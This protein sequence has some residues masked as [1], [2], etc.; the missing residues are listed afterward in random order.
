MEKT[1]VHRRPVSTGSNFSSALEFLEGV[2][3]GVS[4]VRKMSRY[5]LVKSVR[6]SRFA[7]RDF[8]T[9]E[10]RPISGGFDACLSRGRFCACSRNFV[11]LVNQR[12]RRRRVQQRYRI[13]FFF[14]LFSSSKFRD[15]FYE[16]EHNSLRIVSFFSDARCAFLF[17]PSWKEEILE[18]TDSKSCNEIYSFKFIKSDE[19]AVKQGSSGQYCNQFYY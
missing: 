9:L 4:I 6:V 12:T 18:Q 8:E 15:E 10:N 17:Y 16:S 19:I 7:H 13:C 5:E 1:V 2:S 3:W 11:G 14:F